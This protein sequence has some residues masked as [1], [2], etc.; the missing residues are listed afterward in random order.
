MAR[1]LITYLDGNDET[2]TAANLEP[3]GSQYIAWVGDG[4]AA[5]FIPISNV[6]SV[7]RQNDEAVTD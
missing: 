4:S 3:S 2:I 6:R 7:V 5:A 1:Y